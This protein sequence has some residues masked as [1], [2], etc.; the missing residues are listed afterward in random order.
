M[1]MHKHTY[2]SE[3]IKWLQKDRTYLFF[4]LFS[5]PKKSIKVRNTTRV[6][7][8]VKILTI[9]GTTYSNLATHFLTLK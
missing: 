3:N 7:V 5:S 4:L 8:S 9:E 2:I 6:N 1:N